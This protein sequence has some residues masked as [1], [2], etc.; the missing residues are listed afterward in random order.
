MYNSINI[1]KGYEL[2]KEI[3]RKEKNRDAYFYLGFLYEYGL[4][5]SQDPKL[6][7]H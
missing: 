4:G 5:V 2:L 7:L 1:S 6:A 3:L